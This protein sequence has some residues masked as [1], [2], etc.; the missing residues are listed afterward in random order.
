[1]DPQ[2]RLVLETAWAALE[3]AAIDPETLRG[4]ATG[5]FAGISLQDYGSVL[6][7]VAG[8]YEGLRL[9]GCL[10]SVVSGRVSYALGLQGPAVTVDTACS[11]LARRAASGVPG[12]ARRRVLARARGWRDRHV[13]AGDVRRV[14]P[15]ARAR[16]GRAQQAVR[17]R[18]RR[19]ELGRGRRHARRRAAVGRAPALTPGA[20]A[21]FAARATNQDGASN[22]LS[23]PNGPS[24]EQVIRQALA[25]AGL[26]ASDVD[27]V[28]AHGTGTRLG[29]PIEAGALLATYG[30]ERTDGPLWLG[31]IKSNIG[32]TQGAAGVAGVIKMVMAMRA[33]LLPATLHVDA[34]TPHVDWSA[35]EVALL[36][37][38]VPWPRSARPRRAGVSSF[39]ISGTN[40]HVVLE[41]APADD[42]AGAR[43]RR[44]RRAV[45]PV[46]EDRGRAARAGA[47]AARP[48]RRPAVAGP[49]G[50]GVVVGYRPRAAG[51]ARRRRGRRSRDAAR[52][53]RRRRRQRAERR[54]R[55]R[56]C[57]CAR[58]GR[59]R[60]PGAG[61]AVARHGAGAVGLRAG[62]RREDAGVRG[63]A[64]ARSWS[65]TCA[66][67]SRAR[68]ARRRSS[69]WT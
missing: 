64:G 17:G 8:E 68:R 43:R 4:S 66:R 65:G 9:T 52:R 58:Q 56:T 60:V 50:R 53:P 62:V 46:G 34:P 33:G 23:A 24:Q 37:E 41:E 31:S 61:L 35:G 6:Q 19:R 25:N 2:Q 20:R 47:A 32:H 27:A 12:A 15:P 38:D 63:C 49:A 67:C 42:R 55:R 28:E 26:A 29:D 54:R 11:V 48:R 22:G 5:V 69:A 57:P 1:M 13:L 30:A 14:Q 7:G 44:R 16:A 40:A 3:D 21:S 51:P 18:G 45:G 39:G 36:T 59:V 10:T